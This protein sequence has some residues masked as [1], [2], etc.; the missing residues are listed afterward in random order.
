MADKT[1]E[2]I[3]G[4][5]WKWIDIFKGDG[6]D[7]G[8]RNCNLCDLFL[9]N[10]CIECPVSVK[11]GTIGCLRT[12]YDLWSDVVEKNGKNG[13]NFPVTLEEMMLIDP[14][15]K[16]YCLEELDYLWMVLEEYDDYYEKRTGNVC[17]RIL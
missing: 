8:A 6:A 12:P 13:K 9:E 10:F 15:A 17:N 7:Y 14:K 1:R 16:D 5:I 2:A 3:V 11:S 4:S